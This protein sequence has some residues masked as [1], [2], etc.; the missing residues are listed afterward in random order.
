MI[1]SSDSHPSFSPPF[2]LTALLAGIFCASVS[3]SRWLV[4]DVVSAPLCLNSAAPLHPHVSYK[5]VKTNRG[6]VEL[7][8]CVSYSCT[9]C[10]VLFL[11][12]SCLKH[13]ATQQGQKFLFCCFCLPNIMNL[14]DSSDFH[15]T[16]SAFL[17]KTDIKKII[18]MKHISPN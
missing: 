4:L 12:F 16:A 18:I 3:V 17:I 8:V 14:N 1:F 11:F 13:R 7:R 10:V 2:S 6:H 15:W 5:G 9:G